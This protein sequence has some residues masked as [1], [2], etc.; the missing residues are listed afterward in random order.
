ML[1]NN[2]TK[3]KV[4]SN[5]TFGLDLMDYF[6]MREHFDKKKYFVSKSNTNTNIEGTIYLTP[7]NASPKEDAYH[8]ATAAF[9]STRANE[10]L[11]SFSPHVVALVELTLSQLLE[12]L[13]PLF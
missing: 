1:K 12:D 3:F 5:E 11:S 4:K 8:H 6:F 13:E 2:K 7:T 10:S 9:H